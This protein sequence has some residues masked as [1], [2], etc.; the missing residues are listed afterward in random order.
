MSDAEA[1]PPQ[2]EVPLPCIQNRCPAL[3]C[4]HHTLCEDPIAAV[5]MM[6]AA[7][8][9]HR[10]YDGWMCLEG[11]TR[12]RFVRIHGDVT[13][14]DATAILRR[15][16]H[17]HGASTQA[18]GMSSFAPSLNAPDQILQRRRSMRRGLP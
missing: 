10:E 18:A 14:R 4:V 7:F 3:A 5:S 17:D 1:G 12:T 8:R 16:F 11:A 15:V 6:P 9:C 13:G 2:L